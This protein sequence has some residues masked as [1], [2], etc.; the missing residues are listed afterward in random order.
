MQSSNDQTHNELTAEQP[1]KLRAAA[2]QQAKQIE[3]S[4]TNSR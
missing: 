2:E 1:A 3:L 4:V